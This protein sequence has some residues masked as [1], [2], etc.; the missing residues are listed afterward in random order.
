[1][2]V[3]P[4]FERYPFPFFFFFFAL[5][6]FPPFFSLE[7]LR[8]AAGGL[9]SE[10]GK[11]DLVLTP[12]PTDVGNVFCPHVCQAL[13]RYKIIELDLRLFKHRTPPCNQLFSSR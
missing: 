9:C 12:G 1:M 3:F 13:N 4:L 8:R 11:P 5:S 7:R 10:T 6:F 2:I